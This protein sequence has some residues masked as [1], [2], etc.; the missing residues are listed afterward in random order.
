MPIDYQKSVSETPQ[1]YNERI[2]L[3]RGD[4]PQN[5]ANMQAIT[6]AALNPVPTLNPV[7]PNNPTV[8]VVPPEPDPNAITM[9]PQQSIGQAENE[10]LR[11]LVTSSLGESALKA[12]KEVAEG[13]P[14]IQATERDLTTQLN[15]LTQE[16]KAIPLGLTTRHAKETG[17]ST[18]GIGTLQRD[19]LRET[20]IKS[21]TVSSLLE[22]TRGNLASAQ[23]RVD[24]AVAAK[25]DPIKE[26]IA[27]VKANLD[28]IINSP[29]YS[30]EDKE[31]ARKQKEIQD[32][33][34]AKVSLNELNQKRVWDIAVEVAKTGRV[35][36]A[37]MQKIRD[38]KSPEDALDIA[39]RSGA[40]SKDLGDSGYTEKQLKTVT[41]LNQDISK[42]S[43][44]SKTTSMRNYGDNVIASLQLGSGVGD[45]AA[46]NQFQKVIDE[47]A[48][49]RDQ[50]VKL[51]Q[52]S[53]SLLNTLKT[54]IK[55]LEKGDQLSPDLRRQMREAVESLY[56][57]QVQALLKDPY[58]SAKTK[59]AEL[60]GILTDDTI[61]G[62]LGEF[63]RP[64]DGLDELPPVD[65]QGSDNNS[66]FGGLLNLFN[67]NQS[68]TKAF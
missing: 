6:S 25:Y 23:D 13:I 24:R 32:E 63:L 4:T 64:D 42:N 50:D 21:L 1:Q 54:K 16:A 14:A 33:R 22:A 17:I 49:T 59:E 56:D 19:Q 10:R 41:K 68:S 9:T 45:I 53:Q 35:G 20:A 52:G 27:A 5:T 51:I 55:K 67:T 31:R 34:E 7:M 48:V 60:N 26:E 58:I 44:Y 37:T 46:I 28:L 40:F 43:T 66:F 8:P 29:A 57:K 3:A 30:V 18:E 38:A 65:S 36:S 39:T 12:E 61:L 15:A 2:A 11:A 47:G 62:E